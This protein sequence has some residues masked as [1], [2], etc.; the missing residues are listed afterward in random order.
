MIEKES[1]LWIYVECLCAYLFYLFYGIFVIG[2]YFARLH[3]LLFVHVCVF[4][5]IWF[6]GSW[7]S[8]Y[9]SC[10]VGLEL[11]FLSHFHDW[12][13]FVTPFF[14]CLVRLGKSHCQAKQWPFWSLSGKVDLHIV[15]N[16]DKNWKKIESFENEVFLLN[17]I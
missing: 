12:L 7:F 8:E 1:K 9:L 13:I 15:K 10:F 17:K 4:A 11:V 3:S 6:F 14:E 5:V 2:I 16:Q